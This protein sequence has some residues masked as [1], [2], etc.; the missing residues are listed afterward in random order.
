M[1]LRQCSQRLRVVPQLSG[2]AHLLLPSSETTVAVRA[3]DARFVKKMTRSQ[4]EGSSE[5]QDQQKM[6]RYL[7]RL[8]GTTI[9]DHGDSQKT[10]QSTAEAS[11]NMPSRQTEREHTNENI[12]GRTGGEND[13]I[14]ETECKD[15]DGLCTFRDSFKYPVVFFILQGEMQRDQLA[16]ADSFVNQAQHALMMKKKQGGES[17]K[18]EAQDR[19]IQEKY[20]NQPAGT[21]RVFIVPDIPSVLKTLASIVDSVKPEKRLRKEKFFANEAKKKF[22][23][24]PETGLPASEAA[25][26]S[27]VAGAFRSWATRSDLPPRDTDVILSVLE[28]LSKITS[29]GEAVLD[30]I[31]I[32]DASKTTLISFFGDLAT[33]TCSVPIQE[34]GS[35]CDDNLQHSSLSNHVDFSTTRHLHAHPRAAAHSFDS[36]SGLSS[37]ILPVEDGFQ[38]DS[39]NRYMH[40]QQMLAS[41]SVPNMMYDA[42]AAHADLPPLQNQV[43]PLPASQYQVQEHGDYPGMQP[44]VATGGMPPAQQIHD[45]TLRRLSPHRIQNYPPGN[46]QQQIDAKLNEYYSGDSNAGYGLG[47]NCYYG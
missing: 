35:T 6:V 7:A 23:P 43:L 26:S 1:K 22:L 11:H 15:V 31:P 45:L 24:D 32:N 16:R 47:N 39:M 30:N 41:S 46:T 9:P 17:K 10:S 36:S 12:A 38:H 18:H 19:K 37:E 3:Y 4:A 28:T 14:I 34:E 20:K 44:G 33:K 13:Q 8:H 25:V 29:A 27:H 40:S 2:G 42:R 5:T 21:A